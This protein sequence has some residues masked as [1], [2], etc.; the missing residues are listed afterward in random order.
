MDGKAFSPAETVEYLATIH[1]V[2]T[3]FGEHYVALLI[4]SCFRNLLMV[5]PE[6]STKVREHLII[7]LDTDTFLNE[8]AS[9][10][11]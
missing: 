11:T 3:E 8:N 6:M 9:E 5:M 4:T 10:I 2:L 1:A 7:N